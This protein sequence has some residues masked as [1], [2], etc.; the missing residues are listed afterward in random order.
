[1]KSISQERECLGHLI[2]LHRQGELDATFSRD[3]HPLPKEAVLNARLTTGRRL[4]YWGVRTDIGV[5]SKTV[6]LFGVEPRE[7]NDEEARFA[8]SLDFCAI[9]SLAGKSAVLLKPSYVIGSG[10]VLQ[11]TNL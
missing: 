10:L 8:A 9:V 4:F 6:A 7:F 5:H 1:M 2:Y 11:G 3:L